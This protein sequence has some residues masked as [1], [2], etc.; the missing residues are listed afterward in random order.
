M[1]H[2]NAPSTAESARTFL[3]QASVGSLICRGAG[4]GVRSLTAVHVTDQPDGQP[5]LHVEEASPVARQL[6]HCP[7]ATLAV[8]AAAPYQA[9][10]LTGRAERL[11]NQDGDRLTVRLSLLAARLIHGTSGQPPCA[12]PVAEFRAACPD[13]LWRQAAPTVAHLAQAHHDELLACVRAHGI[14]DALAVE[15]T[16][17]DSYGLQL[18][19]IGLQGVRTVRLRFPGAPVTSMDEVGQGIRALMTC[20]CRSCAGHG[21]NRPTA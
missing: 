21:R 17:L 5:L 20:R 1:T 14:T 19:V 4:G 11:P 9:L 13:P 18:A 7:M 15:P 8:S 6:P 2:R 16:A 3:A 12:L 10:H